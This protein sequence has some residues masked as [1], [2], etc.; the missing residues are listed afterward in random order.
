MTT[1]TKITPDAPHPGDAPLKFSGHESFALR[2]G[3]L[4]KL[5]EALT[6]DAEVF[7][8]GE[9]AILALGLGK[10]MVK[11]IRFWGDAFGTSETVGRKVLPT[12]FAKRLMDPRTGRDPY[13]EQQ[14]SL[15]RLHWNLLRRGCLGAWHVVFE[16]LRDV[17]ISR[18]RLVAAVVAEAEKGGGTLSPNTAA[19]HV[20]MLVRSYAGTREIEPVPEEGARMPAAGAGPAPLRRSARQARLADHA[21][22][23]GDSGPFVVRLRLAR[24][25]DGFRAEG[26]IPLPSDAAAWTEV[27][28]T[29]L[30]D[31]RGLAPRAPGPDL[32]RDRRPGDE[33]G[34]RGRRGP[35]RD[36]GRRDR[37]T[38]GDRMV[39]PTTID[40][41]VGLTRRYVRATEMVRDM[42][43]PSALDGYVVTASVREATRRVVAGLDPSSGQRAF[44]VT[45][46]YGSG[47][48]SFGLFLARLLRGDPVAAALAEEHIGIRAV[49]PYVPVALSGRRASFALDL[50]SAVE[51]AAGKAGIG[52]ALRLA[53]ASRAASP[54]DTKLALDALDA[55]ADGLSE[56]GGH[57]LVLLIDEM[58]RYLEY[59][60]AHPREEDPSIF[61][62]LA[63]RAG[64]QGGAPLAVV[65]FLHHR[66]ADYVAGFG[67]WIQAEWA[68]SAERY[69]EVAFADSAEQT[70]FLLSHAL[71]PIVP[72]T[73][74]V[75]ERAE[76][77]FSEAGQRALFTTAPKEL[78]KLSA[79]LYPLHPSAGR[80]TVRRLPALGPERALRVRLPAVARTPRLPALLVRTR[81]RSG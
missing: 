34:R 65:G 62:R 70:L 24:L 26:A 29:G 30:R 4:P 31:G 63:E 12:S 78:A 56:K 7:A 71:T 5:H 2:Y 1:A 13:L 16:E 40:R 10:N 38:G 43:D 14:G 47:K 15:W 8:S 69:E 25:L 60:A 61:Q 75:L 42:D 19:A 67:D 74:A 46:P 32:Q 18:E 20:D 9:G 11:S 35:G 77:A 68:K 22:S 3:W 17:E 41:H 39:K 76:H 72:H 57:G 58:G 44:R 27:A 64:G 59:A 6:L 81:L 53:A 21:R 28:R 55:L 66:F 73:Q 54:L 33:G 80:D 23:K 37:G 52:E 51:R 49:P 36:R 48:S 79:S 50:L 45:G